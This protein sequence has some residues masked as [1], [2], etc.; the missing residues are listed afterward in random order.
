[1]S[2]LSMN[3]SDIKFYSDV[4]IAERFDV[5][6][7]WLYRNRQMNDCIPYKRIGRKI[8]YQHDE[9][10]TWLGHDNVRL[11]TSQAL[12]HLLDVNVQW[13]KKNCA[14]KHAIPFMKLE[15]LVR[16]HPQAVKD[17]LD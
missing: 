6:Q 16:Y 1:M 13:L 4:E 8:R 3:Y 2:L 10:V 14:N 17:W 7:K 12:A 5:S 9:L 15:R 11:L